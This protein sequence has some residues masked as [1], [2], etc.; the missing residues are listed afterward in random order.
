MSESRNILKLDIGSITDFQK[1]MHLPAPTDPNDPNAKLEKI[2]SRFSA[3]FEKTS[4][5]SHTKVAMSRKEGEMNKVQ[6]TASKKF[7]FLFKSELRTVAPAIKVREEYGNKVQIC[8]PR[9]SVTTILKMLNS[10]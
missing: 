10:Y 1:D 5:S 6:Y 9:N 3:I 8:W 2:D 4:W 7:D